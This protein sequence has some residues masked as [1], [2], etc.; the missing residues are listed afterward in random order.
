MT[1]LNHIWPWSRIA[2]LEAELAKERKFGDVAMTALLKIDPLWLERDM[3]E[4]EMRSPRLNCIITG[5]T[6]PGSEGV[7]PD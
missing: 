1:I 6:A 3:Y 5:I 4:A 7:V 2:K